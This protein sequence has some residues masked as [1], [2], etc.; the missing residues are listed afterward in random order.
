MNVTQIIQKDPGGFATDACE[1]EIRLILEKYRC[2]LL[3]IGI[4][5]NGVPAGGQFVV[6]PKNPAPP[7]TLV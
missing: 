2:D 4:Y 7:V 3:F 1:T 6:E 5:R